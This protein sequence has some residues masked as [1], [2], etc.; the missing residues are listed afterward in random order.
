M[1]ACILVA[2]AVVAF[3]VLS[4]TLQPPQVELVE[5]KATSPV[6]SITLPTRYGVYAVAGGQ[7][8]ELEALPGQVSEHRIVMTM[9]PS[10]TI[11]PNGPLSFIIYRPDMALGAPEQVEVRAFAQT[12]PSVWTI[13][14]VVRPLSAASLTDAPEMVQIGPEI[15][16]SGRYV[17]VIKGQPYDFAVRE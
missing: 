6:G 13:G 4:R 2:M 12:R 1:K 8:R 14:K 11:F 10:R 16:D 5:S 9:K 15:L 17:L 7:V 3:L